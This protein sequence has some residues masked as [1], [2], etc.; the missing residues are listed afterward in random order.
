ML[1]WMWFLSGFLAGFSTLS[2]S[3][4]SM[5]TPSP[6]T[7][8]TALDQ[9]VSEIQVKKELS[10]DFDSSLKEL[11]SHESKSQYREKPPTLSN[12]PRLKGPIERVSRQRYRQ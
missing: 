2:M 8:D 7:D 6:L 5:P 4:A 11:H 3:Q 10:I 12:S 1:K 9:Q